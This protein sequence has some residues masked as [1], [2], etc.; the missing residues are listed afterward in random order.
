MGRTQ[1]LPGHF[2]AT[3]CSKA[4]ARPSPQQYFKRTHNFARKGRSSLSPVAP[5]SK[6][7]NLA[8]QCSRKCSRSLYRA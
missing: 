3:T 5:L 7:V 6:N 1:S 4:T 2:S 8:K